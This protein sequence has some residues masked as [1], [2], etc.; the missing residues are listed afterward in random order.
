LR[1][2]IYIAEKAAAL[3]SRTPRLRVNAHPAHKG[4]INHQAIVTRAE[5]REAVAS[6]AD[7]SHYAGVRCNAHRKLNVRNIRAAR[8]QTRRA[9][10]HPVPDRPRVG[11]F[12]VARTQQIAAE[13][14]S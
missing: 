12:A 5:P 1:G 3:K 9:S 6:A 13:S 10:H 11:I 7:R 14:L 2:S 8:D 4:K